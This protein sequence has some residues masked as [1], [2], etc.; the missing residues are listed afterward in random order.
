M[1]KDGE[2]VLGA[3]DGVPGY[4]V[5]FSHSGATMGLIAGE[6]LAREIVSGEVS[7]LLATFRP[8]R[9]GRTG[10]PQAAA[11]EAVADGALHETIR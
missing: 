2:P 9:F 8:G 3:L 1:P 7:P 11:S 4:Y 5:A 10:A 6:L